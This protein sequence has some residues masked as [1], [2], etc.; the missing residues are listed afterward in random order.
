[1]N[2][3]VPLFCIACF[4]P[5]NYKRCKSDIS[6]YLA[7][8]ARTIFIVLSAVFL[9]WIVTISQ[10]NKNLKY[11]IYIYILGVGCQLL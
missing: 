4:A 8:D 9:N 2:V 3:R 1:M 6:Y 5:G 7:V 11:I 10:K